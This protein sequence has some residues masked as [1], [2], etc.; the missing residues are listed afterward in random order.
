MIALA[1]SSCEHCKRLLI[2]RGRRDSNPP[3]QIQQ[4]AQSLDPA[5]VMNLVQS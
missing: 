4:K 3:G 2:W 1:A 5:Q